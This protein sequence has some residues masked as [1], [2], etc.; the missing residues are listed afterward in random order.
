MS[1]KDKRF[2]NLSSILFW[3][4]LGIVLFL[5]LPYFKNGLYEDES[6]I[7]WVK[8]FE[9]KKIYIDSFQKQQND[10]NI[11]INWV[12]S[13]FKNDKHEISFSVQLKDIIYAKEYRKKYYESINVGNLYVD[14]IKISEPVISS[15]YSAMRNDVENK[16]LNKFDVMNYIVSAIQTPTYTKIT[17]EPNEC[18]CKD[19][20][21]DWTSDC[22]PRTDGKGCCNGVI[23]FAVYTPA[24][25]IYQK[26]GDCDTKTIIAYALFKKFGFDA[27]VLTGYTSNDIRNPGGHC[28]LGVAGVKPNMPA[29][30]VKYQGH[31]YYP[32][33]VTNFDPSFV[34][35]NMNM[36]KVWKD[37]EVVCN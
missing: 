2:F 1:V 3:V 7:K 31:I 13:D 20:G 26:T 6:V 15:M 16:K 9:K 18:P 36:W 24:E 30:T 35:G 28:M 34:L 5:C 19:M 10:K 27:A 32:W 25:F 23:P 12:W 11:S 4:I 14:F 33:E 17:N 29:S 37:W 22:Y 21:I 8:N